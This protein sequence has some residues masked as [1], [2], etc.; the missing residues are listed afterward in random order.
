MKILAAKFLKTVQLPGTNV[1][2]EVID[3]TEA[4]LAIVGPLL[5]IT[6]AGE[7]HATPLSN[8]RQL[9]VEGETSLKTP[10]MLRVSK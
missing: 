7:A 2:R 5:L 3:C 9:R 8:V 4:T 6:R 1:D 10:R